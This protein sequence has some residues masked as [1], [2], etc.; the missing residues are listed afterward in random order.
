MQYSFWKATGAIVLIILPG[1]TLCR[2]QSVRWGRGLPRPQ[3]LH[4]LRVWDVQVCVPRQLQGLR[5]QHGQRVRERH[6]DG[7]AQLWWLPPTLPCPLQCHRH[8][9]SRE[10]CHHLRY[11]LE[12][13]LLDISRILAMQVLCN[14][15][16]F[17]SVLPPVLAIPPQRTELMVNNIFLGCGSTLIPHNNILIRT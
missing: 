6:Y 7:R 9:R 3:R 13:C 1:F 16:L 17:S 2:C 8:L 12:P 14:A 4:H 5:P 15:L 10:V 11:W